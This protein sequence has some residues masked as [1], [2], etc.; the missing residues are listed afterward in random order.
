VT[1]QFLTI[2]HS[3]GE[4]ITTKNTIITVVF[5]IATR[6]QQNAFASHRDSLTCRL[7]GFLD[8]R[9]PGPYH[10]TFGLQ[11]T[12]GVT[13]PR[14]QSRTR[15]RDCQRPGRAS[16]SDS[17]SPQAQPPRPRS[18]VTTGR[19]G[20]VTVTSR[21][22][23]LRHRPPDSIDHWHINFSDSDGGKPQIQVTLALASFESS[24]CHG[25]GVDLPP[26]DS[27]S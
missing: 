16:E 10:S 19:D 24:H 5:P 1:G 2:R 11:W 26:A 18:R 15:H 25:L 21:G 8:V 27:D 12:A 4:Q 22:A 6:L 14:P 23:A 20:R 9:L 3:I 17:E 13:L 7:A